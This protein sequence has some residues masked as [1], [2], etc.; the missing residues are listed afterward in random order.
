[1]PGLFPRGAGNLEE[2]PQVHVARCIVEEGGNHAAPS[3]G[4]VLF[5]KALHIAAQADSG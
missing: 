3:S 1:M 4:S 5:G 2:V